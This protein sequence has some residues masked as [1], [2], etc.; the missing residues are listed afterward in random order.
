MVIYMKGWGEEGHWVC[1]YEM[2]LEK[3]IKSIRRKYNSNGFSGPRR[4]SKMQW[5][6]SFRHAKPRNGQNY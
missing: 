5:H 1:M 3:R 4:M 2:K 6:K